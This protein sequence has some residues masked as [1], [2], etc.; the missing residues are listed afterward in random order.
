MQKIIAVGSDHAGLSLKNAL[1]AYLMDEG[2]TV[3]DKGTYDEN[4]CDYPDFAVAVA[5]D[6]AAKKAHLGLLVCS[7]GI[8]MSMTA[9]KIAGARAALVH[10]GYEAAMTR[11]HND[12]NILCLGANIIGLALAQD[13]LSAF[14]HTEFE[15]NRHQRRVDKM[16]AQERN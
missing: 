10:N 2:Y 8:G 4:S 12:A 3:D 13:A 1:C 6:V 9:N 14:I 7:T 5:K 15:G 16:M 11:K